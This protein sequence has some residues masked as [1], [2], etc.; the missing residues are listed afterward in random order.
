MIV[1]MPRRLAVLMLLAF[2]LAP[3]AQ[4]ASSG[5]VF[6]IRAAG[7][8]KLG[9]FV[10]SAA[11]GGVKQGAIIVSNTGDRSGT[12]KLY[13]A[14]ATT[15]R[16]T[17]TV[18]L[19]DKPPTHAGSWVKLAKSSLTLAP[20]AHASVPFTVTVPAGTGAGQWVG[21]I[22]AETSQAAQ[23]PKKKQKANVQIRIRNLTI[24][25]VQVNVPGPTVVS[26][27]LGAVTTGGQR[28]FQQ[29]IV[30][31]E[32]TGTVLSK[33]TGT[34]TI[35][36]SGSKVIERLAFAMDTFLPHTAID[37]PV[38]LKKALSPGDYRAQIRLV[39]PGAG[40]AG[41]KTVTAN[42]SFSVSKQ[43]VTQVFT[44]TTPTQQAPGSSSSGGGSTSWPLLAAAAAALLVLV[45]L[46]LLL[47]RRRRAQP[48][49]AP[50]SASAGPPVEPPLPGAPAEAAATPWL[51]MATPWMDQTGVDETAVPL[52]PA[53]AAAPPVA[54]API[55]AAVPV[56]SAVPEPLA[57]PAPPP[58]PAAAP[59]PPAPPAPPVPSA[60]AV[61]ASAGPGASCDHLWEVAYD[62]GQL[63]GDGVWRFPHRCRNC[64][65]ELFAADIADAN[66][67][68]VRPTSG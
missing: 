50:R 25:A 21:G 34:V 33:P 61:A 27:A 39:A 58:A 13:S 16:T 29:V 48:H 51:D 31:I 65:L 23:G 54:A 63:G 18:Y 5:P 30:H 2:V 26:F 1:G 10:Y 38:L 53:A 17:G 35:F 42:R 22:V 46:L 32:N 57:P 62:R 67:Q 36:G 47:I 7:N 37:Y 55:P 68:A 15:G 11:P 9:Y 8:P 52:A 4:A 56:P 43:D 28:G 20:G 3:G 60:A 12:V 64:G 24:V 49:A 6:G 59:A 44:S 14:D 66:A 45:S 41:V 40:G 19:T